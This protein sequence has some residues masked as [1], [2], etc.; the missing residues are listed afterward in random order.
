MIRQLIL[1]LLRTQDRRLEGVE[2]AQAIQQKTM[3]EVKA[4]VI[5]MN[6]RLG[7]LHTAVLKSADEQGSAIRANQRHAME[8]EARVAKLERSSGG[9]D[10]L[11]GR[12]LRLESGPSAAE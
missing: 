1:R 2:D 9:M 10:E 7:E 11:E 5:G 8:T 6:E 4:I 12:V 3:D